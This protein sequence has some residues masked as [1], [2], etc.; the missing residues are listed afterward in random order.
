MTPVY[1][2]LDHEIMVYRYGMSQT[3]VAIIV[4]LL[5]LILPAVGVEVGSDQL[6]GAIQTIVLIATS[7]WIWVRRY[8]AGDIKLFGARK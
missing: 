2:N 3:I 5:T 4:Q 7:L 8:Q 6:T 1:N